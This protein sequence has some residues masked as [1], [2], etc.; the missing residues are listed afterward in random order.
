LS[1][2]RCQRPCGHRC[3]AHHVFHF[4]AFLSENNVTVKA[5]GF[6]LA[7]GVFLDAFVVRLTLVPA[8]MAIIRG[9]FWYHPQWFDRFIPDLDIE[10]EQLKKSLVMAAD[11]TVTATVG[12]GSSGRATLLR[13]PQRLDI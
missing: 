2:R 12:T 5:I 7:V 11:Q 6:G 13:L 4:V 9:K 8:V 3:R 1:V 10:G